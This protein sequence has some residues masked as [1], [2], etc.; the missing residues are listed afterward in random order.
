M[1]ENNPLN[2]TEHKSINGV[3]PNNSIGEKESSLTTRAGYANVSSFTNP[4]DIAF[5]F[6]FTVGPIIQNIVSYDVDRVSLWISTSSSNTADIVLAF[7]RNSSIN[8][9]SGLGI[10]GFRLSPGKDRLINYRGLVY[11]MSATAGQILSVCSFKY[12]KV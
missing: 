2:A 8:V 5:E 9:G 4:S 3:I 11:A 10:N 6:T 12:S 1:S 7:S